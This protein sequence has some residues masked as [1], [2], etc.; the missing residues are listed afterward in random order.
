M[1][2]LRWNMKNVDRKPIVVDKH[3]KGRL[4]YAV[5]KD[6]PNQ[7]WLVLIH[8]VNDEGF[9]ERHISIALKHNVIN[10]NLMTLR[11]GTFSNTVYYDFYEPNEK[12]KKILKKVMKSKGVKFVKA[13]NKLIW[14]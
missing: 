12:D 10:I 4:V 9:I 8:S 2:L 14:R 5:D 1:R 6:V 3:T 7:D 11:H 13:I